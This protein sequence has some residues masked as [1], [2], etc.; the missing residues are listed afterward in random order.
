[1]RQL[2]KRED[3]LKCA[4]DPIRC[5][6][7]ESKAQFEGKLR[8][9]LLKGLIKP[10]TVVLIKDAAHDA[11][12]VDKY[13]PR[14]SGPYEVVCCTKGGSYVIQELDGTPIRQ[15]YAAFRLLPYK[16]RIPSDLEC[17]PILTKIQ[18]QTRP[19]NQIQNHPVTVTSTTPRSSIEL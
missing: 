14:Y 6:R 12:L 16:P 7:I 17:H 13:T 18:T 9:R 3:D 1:M 19:M 8:H 2:D 10:G 15:G 11:G 5:S 4:A